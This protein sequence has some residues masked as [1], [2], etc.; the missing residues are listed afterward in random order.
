MKRKII[1]VLVCIFLVSCSDKNGDRFSNAEFVFIEAGVYTIGSPA[2]EYGRWP[3]GE[4]DIRK[5][6]TPGFYMSR[7]EITEKQYY[8]VVA[9]DMLVAESRN[10]PVVNVSWLDAILYCNL[11]SKTEG[12]QEVYA[13]G[14]GLMTAAESPV[15]MPVV[16]AD[17]S[18]NGYRLPTI[19]EWEIA[20]RAKTRSAYYTGRKMTQAQANYDSQGRMPVGSFPPNKFGLL[21]MGGNV[22]EWCWRNEWF[23]MHKGGSWRSP[24]HFL[25]SSAVAF[26]DGFCKSDDVGFRVVKNAF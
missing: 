11:R 8:S 7:T 22:A 17:E 20:C 16:T 13:I 26:S 10:M 12:L 6:S 2:G 15:P 19:D 1:L 3:K 9:P 25:R 18:A 5:T 21:D 4:E 23:A 14:E 24:M